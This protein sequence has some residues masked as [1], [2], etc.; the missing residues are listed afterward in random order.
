M[1]WAKVWPKLSSARSPRSN[2]SRS[3]IAALCAQ[4]RAIASASAVSSRR[5]QRRRIGVEPVQERRIDDR[6]VLDHLRE[7]GAQFARRQR[8]Q[9]RRIGEHR[10][11]RMERA[12]Q[13]LALR[14]VHRGLAADRRIDHRQQA[15]SA[16]APRRCRA[17]STP[18]RS[19]RGRRR[20][21]HRARTR[22]RRGSRRNRRVRAAVRRS[23]P[24]SWPIR[25]P[26]C[27]SR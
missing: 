17:S 21:R 12:D 24:R 1:A 8:A 23:W 26:Q 16:T 6:A 13:V 14:Q 9:R 7:A 19:R 2:G 20:R 3:T 25:R 10:A 15:S 11:R 5:E 18:P 22:T 27:R 4:L